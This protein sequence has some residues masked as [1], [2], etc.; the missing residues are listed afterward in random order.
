MTAG[1]LQGLRV[2]ELGSLIGGPFCGTLMAEFGA[3]VVKVEDPESGDAARALGVRVDGTSTFFASIGRNKRC[4]TLDL[5]RPQGQAV[6]EQL[7]AHCDVLI[8]NFRVGTLAAWNLD[9]AR[10]SRV[11]PRLVMAHVSGFGQTGPYR[12]RLAFDRVATAFAGQDFVTGFP[13]NP[14][15]RPGGA[16]ADYV[17]GLFCTIGVM[18]ALRHRDHVSGRGQEIDLALYEGMLRLSGAVEAF[19]ATGVVP[20]RQGNTNPNIAPAE[21]FRTRDGQWLVINAGTDNVWRRLLRLMGREELDRDPR[22]ATAG[23][24]AAHH[25]EVNPI[26]AAWVAAHDLDA[27]LGVL[28]REQV[29]ATRINSIADVVADPHVL[30]RGNVIETVLESGR[31]LLSIG[32]VPKLS[33][34]PGGVRSA[35]P[36]LGAHNEA[37]YR[38][39]LGMGEAQYEA[40][41]RERII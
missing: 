32:V 11:N 2:L 22:F 7:V 31:R 27:L 18:F 26:V 37:V 41:R 13:D 1:A 21:T 16:L 19:G 5:R 9:Y 40:L 25:A 36:A 28:E 4:V 33:E 17:S 10:L 38:G 39:L 15:T 30:A 24:R 35:A 8:E 20:T 12:D 6:L 23:A 29:P 34:S 14:P 3:D